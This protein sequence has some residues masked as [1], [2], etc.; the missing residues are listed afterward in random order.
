MPKTLPVICVTEGA[1]PAGLTPAQ[2]KWAKA[3]GFTG[4]RGRLLAL[5]GEDGSVAG[6]LFVLGAPAGRP[7]LVTGLASSALEPGS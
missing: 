3:S 2:G 1:A 5:P 7:K 4:Q 6:Y